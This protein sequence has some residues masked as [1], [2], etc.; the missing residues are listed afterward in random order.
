MKKITII[1]AAVFLV[2]P[3]ILHAQTA[4]DLENV[5]KARTVSCAQAAWY[6]VAAGSGAPT[7]NTAPLNIDTAYKQ[8]TTHGWLKDTRPN[9]PITLDKLSFLMMQAFGMEGGIM[10]FF[11]PCP[12][13][14][15][16]S[17]VSRSYIQGTADPTM[18]VS[19]ERFLIILGKVLSARG[20][21]S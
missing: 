20:D 14:A 3:G 15:Y 18:T 8:A 7:K 1:L 4:A 21:G 16:R 9:E 5:L 12:R 10:Y 2:L 11:L 17:M 13:Y 19:G 6:V